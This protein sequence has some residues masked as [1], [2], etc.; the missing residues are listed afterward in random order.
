MTVIPATGAIGNGGGEVDAT[1]AFASCEGTR[2]WHSQRERKLAPEAVTELALA[3]ASGG[4]PAIRRQEQR[5]DQR[6]G[7]AGAPP[8]CASFATLSSAR[9][10]TGRVPAAG[11]PVTAGRRL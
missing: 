3:G 2:N 9:S 10:A 4:G 1:D 5:G 8:P 11:A 6:L 7:G